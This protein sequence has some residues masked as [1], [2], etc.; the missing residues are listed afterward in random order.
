MPVPDKMLDDSIQQQKS[1]SKLLDSDSESVCSECFGT[2]T[3]VDQV[4]GAMPCVCTRR[5]QA[6]RLLAAAHI[7]RRYVDCSFES[8]KTQPGTSQ[9]NALLFA[10][11]LVIDFP[12]VDRGLLL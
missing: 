4:K 12:A 8:F 2:G 5:N 3:K 10:R 1:Q 9:D 7:P 6:K 11:T